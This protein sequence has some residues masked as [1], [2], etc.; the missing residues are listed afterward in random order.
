MVPI[1]QNALLAT[2]LAA[3]SI[4]VNR[5]GFQHKYCLVAF[6][7][8]WETV[9][10][11]CIL[12]TGVFL[13]SLPVLKV[14]V[15]FLFLFLVCASQSNRDG[16]GLGRLWSSLG[17]PLLTPLERYFNQ[18]S[19][20]SIRSSSS[21]SSRSPS[22]SPSSPH[23]PGGDRLLRRRLFHEQR[24]A[25]HDVRALPLQW[26]GWSCC[27]G[28]IRNKVDGFMYHVSCLFHWHHILMFGGNIN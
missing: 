19:S 28:A 11:Q 20:R 27:E 3:F 7:S 4:S 25:H 2:I 10:M 5:S 16:A 12:S 18:S 15:S 9:Q 8:I 14:I 21:S 26:L 23:G 17:W 24:A 22:S 13:I 6:R 1:V